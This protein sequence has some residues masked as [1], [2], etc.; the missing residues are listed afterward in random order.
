[1]EKILIYG[2]GRHAEVAADLM[3]KYKLNE[4]VGFTVKK[5]YYNK[6]E[7]NGYPIYPYEHIE[8]THPT[9]K[10]K[11][12]IAVGPQSINRVREDLF[13]DIKS[14]GYGFVNCIC[15]SPFIEDE[16]KVGE[17][18]F[19]D[20]FCWI[21]SF[22]EIGD[23][24][25]LIASKIGHHCKIGDNCFISSSMLAGNVNVMKNVFIGL[26]SMI[27]PNIYLGEYTLVGMGCTISKSTDPASVYTNNSTKRR[28]FDSFKLK[29]L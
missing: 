13:N 17:N 19:I 16:I 20:Q 10:F 8:Q 7:L 23:N 25:T 2:T 14:K 12:F 9:D 1:M 15:P 24:T 11:M 26:G 21:S 4:V 18:V 3:R 5:E 29:I 22:V 28:D 6:S 27:G